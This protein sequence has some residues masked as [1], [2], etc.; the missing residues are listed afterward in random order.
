MLT[1]RQPGVAEQREAWF[2]ELFRVRG[3][4]SGFAAGE[5]VGCDPGRVIGAGP[6]GAGTVIAAAGR[7]CVIVAWDEGGETRVEVTDLFSLDEG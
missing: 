1:K 2:G 5:R 6:T 4:A 7:G 3:Q